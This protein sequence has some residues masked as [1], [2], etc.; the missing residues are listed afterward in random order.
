MFQESLI[1]NNMNLK[2]QK[3]LIIVGVLAAILLSLVFQS[4]A[5]AGTTGLEFKGLYDFIYGA[6]TGYLGRGICIFAGVV[7]IATGA[8]MG[9]VM[10]AILGVILAVFGTLGPTIVNSLF[11]SAII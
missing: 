6:A 3:R 8:G 10:P 5:Y 9:R 7:G 1:M 2:E 4:A 11:K